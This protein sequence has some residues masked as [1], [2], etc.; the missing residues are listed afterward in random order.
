MKYKNILIFLCMH[1][2][3]CAAGLAASGAMQIP[4]ELV[5]LKITGFIILAAYAA[6]TLYTASNLEGKQ[7]IFLEVWKV[8]IMAVFAVVVFSHGARAAAAAFVTISPF[9]PLIL[10]NMKKALLTCGGMFV[11]ETAAEVMLKRN[12]DKM[13]V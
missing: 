3:L 7:L 11:I 2:I 1:V 12:N 10:I 6:G 4:G 13:A 9:R 5:K 8:C